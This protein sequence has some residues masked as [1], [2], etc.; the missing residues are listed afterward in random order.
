MDPNQNA[1]PS[2]ITPMPTDEIVVQ[3]PPFNHLNRS[4]RRRENESS[5]YKRPKHASSPNNDALI[6]PDHPMPSQMDLFGATQNNPSWEIAQIDR[7]ARNQADIASAISRAH[8]VSQNN[9]PKSTKEAYNSK[10][11]AWKNWCMERGF[12]DL[13]TVSAGKLI[14]WLQERVIPNG[15]QHKG[16]RHGA[17]LT[18]SGLEGYIKPV[19]ALYEVCIYYN[20]FFHA[21]YLFIIGSSNDESEFKSV[22]SYSDVAS[23]SPLQQ[24]GKGSHQC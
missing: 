11:E 2:T 14:L 16:A 17:M 3:D 8:F 5:S 4:N 12:K 10:Q 9:R 23:C 21:E 15:V 1:F 19:I 6:L 13:D 20:P 22:S 18:E 7:E 24:R